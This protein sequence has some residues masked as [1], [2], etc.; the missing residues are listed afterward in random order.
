RPARSRSDLAR[1]SQL[2]RRGGAVGGS[3]SQSPFRFSKEEDP[4]MRQFLR[5]A[6]ARFPAVLALLL[7]LL[8]PRI[9]AQATPGTLRGN[10]TDGSGGALPGVTVEAVNDESG[11]RTTAYTEQQT[12]FYNMSLPPGNYTVT[13]TLQGL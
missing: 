5:G 12:G 10:V 6:L 11:Y 9:V 4:G 1:G 8:P 2:Q 7:L 13:A 3:S